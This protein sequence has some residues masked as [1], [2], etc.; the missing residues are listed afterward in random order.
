MKQNEETFHAF[1]HAA[2]SC[3]VAFAIIM[4]AV[5]PALALVV[6][7]KPSPASGTVPFGPRPL[8]P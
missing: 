7:V 6:S 2:L 8:L 3:L 4:L 5:A 1:R